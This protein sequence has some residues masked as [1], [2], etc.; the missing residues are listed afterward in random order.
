MVVK[1]SNTV[2]PQRQKN[3]IRSDSNGFLSQ[4]PTCPL[5]STLGET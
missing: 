4:Y 2:A 1:Q 3:W 5:C